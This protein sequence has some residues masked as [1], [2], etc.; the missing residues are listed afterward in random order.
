MRG[1]GLFD[2]E[3]ARHF[4]LLDDLLNL[5]GSNLDVGYL[6]LLDNEHAVDLLGLRGAE[7]CCDAHLVVYLLEVVEF[8]H[9]SLEVGVALRVVVEDDEED[10]GD[11][12]LLAKSVDEF[13][14]V[15][16]LDDA[17]SDVYALNP[18]A[19]HNSRGD[20]G[21]FLLAEV[22]VYAV[23]A[24]DG[25]E[26]QRVEVSVVLGET[27]EGVEVEELSYVEPVGEVLDGKEVGDDY[28][29]FVESVDV[30]EVGAVCTE[31]EGAFEGGAV[32]LHLF[33]VVEDALVEAGPALLDLVCHLDRRGDVLDHVVDN[34]LRELQGCTLKAIGDIVEVG[35]AVAAVA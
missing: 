6:V 25:E 14:V 15:G 24:G 12:F 13:G 23:E 18:C 31:V 11:V 33:G 21:A 20:V 16:L 3:L 27:G 22:L 34:V 32:V 26:L 7:L 2:D 5:L 30:A 19:S 10:G 17:A 8:G 28:T 1:G 9:K 29:V 35:V 4:D